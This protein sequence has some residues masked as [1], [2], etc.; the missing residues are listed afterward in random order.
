MDKALAYGARD[1]GFKSHRAWFFYLPFNTNQLTLINYT[2]KSL[3]S[4][5]A[6]I[7]HFF[8]QFTK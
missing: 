8:G 6:I 2:F 5:I 1:C 4:S 3:T 7:N